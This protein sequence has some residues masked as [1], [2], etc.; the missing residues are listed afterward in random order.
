MDDVP[1][2]GD[3][4]AII[5]EHNKAVLETEDFKKKIITMRNYRNRTKHVFEVLERNHNA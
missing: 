4:M 3:D 1:I 2:I 5:N